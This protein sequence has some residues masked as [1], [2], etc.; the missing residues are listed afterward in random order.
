M[1]RVCWLIRSHTV[2]KDEG[3]RLLRTC[4][5]ADGGAPLSHAEVLACLD[6]HK[7]GSMFSAREKMSILNDPSMPSSWN[8]GDLSLEY[9]PPLVALH[10]RMRGMDWVKSSEGSGFGEGGSERG[11]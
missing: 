6:A 8:A 11:T 7:I 3:L 2:V 10:M 9:V 1:G 4:A 5:R